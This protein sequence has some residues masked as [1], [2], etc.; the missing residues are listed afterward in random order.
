VLGNGADG[1]WSRLERGELAMTAFCEAFDAE[2]VVAGG[3]I[4]STVLMARIAE[5]SQPRPAMVSAIRRIRAGGL[6]A[7]ALT[8]NWDSDDQ[9]QKM[10]LL[11]AEFDVFIESVRVGLR[12]PDP[13]IYEL[14]CRQLEVAPT[15]AVFLDDIGVNLKAARALGITT[16][17]VDDPDVALAELEG[18]LGIALRG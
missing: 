3:S 10:D 9:K 4:V 15:E 16:I 1:A 6:R 14:A 11:R 13:R 2:A 12:K 7:G 8:N 17:K 5:Y 18:V